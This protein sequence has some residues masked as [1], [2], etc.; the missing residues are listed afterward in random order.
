MS[1]STAVTADDLGLHAWSDRCYEAL[2]GREG[3]RR[4]GSCVLGMDEVWDFDRVLEGWLEHVRERLAPHGLRYD[5]GKDLVSLPTSLGFGEARHLCS[6][7]AAGF[8]AWIDGVVD[9]VRAGLPDPQ[10]WDARSRDDPGARW[11]KWDPE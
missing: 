6:E 3:D 2:V 5:L 11:V 8:S 10:K 1:A 4:D 9:E 7:V